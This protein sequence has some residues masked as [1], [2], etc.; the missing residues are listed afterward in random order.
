MI[1]VAIRKQLGLFQLEPTFNAPARG[2][3]AL[4]GPSGCGKSATLLAIAGLSPPD[5][6]RIAIGEHVLLDSDAGI[7]LAA[8]DRAIGFVFQ[9][10]R[11]FPHL[12]VKA[13][14]EYGMKRR[15][16]GTHAPAIAFDRAV[17]ALGL[18]GLLERRPRN[19]SGGEKQRVA[20][21][22]ALLSAP[23]LLLLDEPMA[24]I[25]EARKAEILPFLER[26]HDILPVPAIYVTHS[27]DEAARIADA[28]VLMDQGRILA[29][30]AIHEILSRADLALLTQRG[31]VGAVL[32]AIV[33]EKDAT[34]GITLLAIGAIPFITS[35]MSATPGSRVRLRVLARDV[36]IALHAPEGLSMQNILPARVTEIVPRGEANSLV[37][38]DLGGTHILSLV[39][40]DSVRRLGLLPGTK[41][42]ALVKS[43]ASGVF[44]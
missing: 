2:V 43:V 41:V 27:L 9:E 42:F 18:D 31:D 35:L 20:I 17:E 15:K 1:S 39:T 44:A 22:R 32:S 28:I 12:S 14:L 23:D 33:T 24:S 34:R 40:S 38:L 36:A 7:D 25:D 10:S 16:A 4:F 26:L 11:L 29:E 19:L 21:G 13:N 30:G 3:T 6:G 5:S 8:E 37:R